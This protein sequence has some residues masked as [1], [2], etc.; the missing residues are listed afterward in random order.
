M[1]VERITVKQVYS[2]GQ[3]YLPL[4]IGM[5]VLVQEGESRDELFW[6]AKSQ[7]DKWGLENYAK[8]NPHEDVT[9]YSAS[10]PIQAVDYRAKE[11][12][13]IAIDNAETIEQLQEI[14]NTAI[15]Y[16]LKDMYYSKLTALIHH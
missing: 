10:Q 13:E 16:G 4:H 11:K 2:T 6:Q 12:L 3:M 7:L 9:Q 15:E 1:T 8:Q 14:H 5:D